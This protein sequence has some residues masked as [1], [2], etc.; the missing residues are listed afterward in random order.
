VHA[1]LTQGK[2]GDDLVPIFWEDNYFSLLPGEE[3][4]V[5]ATFDAADLHGKEPFLEVTGYNV[6]PAA[7][8]LSH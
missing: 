2:D 6:N 5:T 3:K 4:T 8:K 7:V 1:R